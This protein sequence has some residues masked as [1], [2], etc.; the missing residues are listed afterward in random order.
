MRFF[1][2]EKLINLHDDYTRRFRIDHRQLLLLQRQG[3]VHLLEATCPHRAQSLE[4]ARIE[5]GVIECPLHHY[6]FALDDGRLLHSS[7]QPC[8]A[9]RTYRIVYVGT[10]VGFMLDDEN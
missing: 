5:D 4:T 8:R 1:P 3:A 6:R 9:L 2:L 10:E 7:E